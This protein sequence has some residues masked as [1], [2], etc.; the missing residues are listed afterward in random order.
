MVPRV[1]LTTGGVLIGKFSRVA[2]R[3]G[4]DCRLGKRGVFLFSWRPGQSCAPVAFPAYCRFASA[5]RSGQYAAGRFRSAAILA[6]KRY[7]SRRKLLVKGRNVAGFCRVE[8]FELSF[9]QS[10]ELFEHGIR[11]LCRRILTHSDHRRQGAHAP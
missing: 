11:L 3:L 4:L 5:S 7:A 10:R 6:D 2:M 1:A 8:A 9:N